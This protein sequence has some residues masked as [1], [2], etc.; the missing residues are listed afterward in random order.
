MPLLII[1]VYPVIEIILYSKFLDHYTW[2]NL[3]G[4]VFGTGF[5]GLS[6]M[7]SQGRQMMVN[8]QSGQGADLSIA[9]RMIQTFLVF[10]GGLMLFTPGLLA[11]FIGIM[12][13]LPGVRHLIGF[14][15]KAF[16]VK[17]ISQGTAHFFARGGAG[18]FA[19]GFTFSTGSMRD[20]GGKFERDVN[21]VDVTP[22]Q[23]EHITQ[24]EADL[25]SK[26]D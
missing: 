13:I 23:V 15:L 1:F 20:V 18:P 7:L 24:I 12:L 9:E 26:K 10:I 11:D 2:L 19:G 14:L 3:L 17:K 21:V 25:K 5:I 8:V 16:L 22:S 4:L 6:I